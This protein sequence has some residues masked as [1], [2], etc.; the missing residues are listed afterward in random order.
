M[1]GYRLQHIPTGLYFC[2]SKKF[3]NKN[4]KFSYHKTNL[5]KFGKIYSKKPTNIQLQL[6]LGCFWNENGDLVR[7]NKKDILKVWKVVEV[8]L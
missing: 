6:W 5:D 1:T 8:E 3:V 7:V 2:N 4:V